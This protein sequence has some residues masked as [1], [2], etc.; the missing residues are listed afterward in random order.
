MY[1][2]S[3]KDI[4][5]YMH[6]T[7]YPTIR[8]IYKG[9]VVK[10]FGDNSREAIKKWVNTQIRDVQ[11]MPNHDHMWKLS[12]T[13]EKMIMYFGEKDSEQY[14]SL[15]KAAKQ[16]TDEILIVGTNIEE[17]FEYFKIDKAETPKLVY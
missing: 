5:A 9:S 2:K 3:E 10:Y 1:C 14:E 12:R 8:Y 13:K 16:I 7:S 17:S 4:C 11:M 6:I 15:N